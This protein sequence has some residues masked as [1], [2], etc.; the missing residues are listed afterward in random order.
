[1][2][3]TAMIELA[4]AYSRRLDHCTTSGG[5]GIDE[6]MT[7][8]TDDATRIVDGQMV[9]RGADEIRAGFL[10]RGQLRDQ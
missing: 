9:Q 1:M 10:R 5:G 3:E 6:L 2:N 8:F 4:L 7:L